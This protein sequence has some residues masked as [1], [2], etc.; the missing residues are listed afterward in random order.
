MVEH[1]QN[2]LEGSTPEVEN[3]LEAVRQEPA[4]ASQEPETSNAEPSASEEPETSNEKL[5]ANEPEAISEEPTASA[6]PETSNEE[7]A[8]S[9]E[10]EAS[11][12]ESAASAEPETSNEKL[13]ASEAEAEDRDHR[14]RWVHNGEECRARGDGECG[15]EHPPQ[16]AEGQPTEDVFFAQRRGENR[17]QG[18]PHDADIG[19]GHRRFLFDGQ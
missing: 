13:E 2:P 16:A 7:P 11:N 14:Q 17:Q 4:A 1:D 8:A 12:E 15:R 6:E 18:G 9:E 5:E 19:G 10:P 3:Q